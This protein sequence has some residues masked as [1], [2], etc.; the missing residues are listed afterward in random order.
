MRLVLTV[1][2]SA[3]MLSGCAAEMPSNR[4]AGLY[5]HPEDPLLLCR[6]ADQ[7]PGLHI[8]GRPLCL[9]KSEWD[10]HAEMQHLASRFTGNPDLLTYNGAGQQQV[11]PN[12]NPSNGNPWQP[13]APR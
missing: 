8:Q 6:K 1:A 3:L 2:I 12:G 7:K 9:T 4:T 5:P 11:A 10:E 13:Y